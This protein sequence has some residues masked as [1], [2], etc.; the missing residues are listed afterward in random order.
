M[1]KKIIVILLVAATFASAQAPAPVDLQGVLERLDKLEA[2][3]ARLRDEIRELRAELTAPAPPSERLDVQESRTAELEQT[4][5]AASQ[6]FP[7]QITGM[8]LFNAYRNGVFTTG[9]QNPSTASQNRSTP[10]DGGS[11][12]Q[13]V[14]GLKFNGPDLPGSGKAGGSFYMDFFAGSTAPNN[15]LPRIRIAT[16]DLTWKNTTVSVGQDKPL[17]S[18][19]EPVSLAQVGIS[20]LTAAGNLWDWNP[21]VRIEQRFHFSEHSGLNAQ[22][23][24][25]ETTENYP[26]NLPQQFANTLTRSRPSYE[27]RLEYFRQSGTR[28]FEIAPS[29]HL[30]TVHVAGASLAS[31]IASVDWL[32]RPA[33]FLEITGEAFRGSAVAGLGSLQGFN[34]SAARVANAVHTDGEWAQIAVSLPAKFSVNAYLG[35]QQN[36]SADLPAGGIN[37]NFV[38]AGNLMYKFAPNVLGA[39][40]AS[41]TRTNYL[42]TGLRMNNHY[43]LALAYMF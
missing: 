14:L 7:L 26:G 30:G 1:L 5:V 43:D 40:E 10:N 21:Q 31:R 38:Y 28:R 11:L 27:G 9:G 3:N 15:S 39:F 18:P 23:S 16:I 36:R 34:V 8:L 22:G 42:G 13:T 37:R 35:Q 41:Q 33:S 29:F 2:E 25:Y 19:R 17:I 20:P 6:R 12:R 4:K 32:F 24:V